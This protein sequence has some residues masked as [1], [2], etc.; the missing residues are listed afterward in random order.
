MIELTKAFDR[1]QIEELPPAISSA[2]QPD[3]GRLELHRKE[4]HCTGIGEESPR[5]AGALCTIRPPSF[6]PASQIQWPIKPFP[7][8]RTTR[9]PTSRLLC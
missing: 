9:A 4:S 2:Q 1:L 3:Y 5:P 7:G 8:L 6:S